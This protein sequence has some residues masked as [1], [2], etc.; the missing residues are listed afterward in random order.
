LYP[1][2][3]ELAREFAIDVQSNPELEA[4]V[5]TPGQE[6][7]EQAVRWLDEMDERIQVHQ[8][9]QFLQTS[10]VMNP[11]GV[12]VLLQHFLGKTPKSDA[13]RDKVDFLL[14]QYFSQLAPTGV[15]DAEVDLGYV[16][17]TLQ[18]VLGQVE[19][20]APV[21]LNALDRILE[22]ARR[23]KSLDELLHGGV[24][25]QGRKAKT[26]AGELFYLPVALTAFTRFG[27]L[28]RRAFFRLM[29]GDLNI[30][31]DGLTEL[32]EKGVQTIDCRR[33]QFS[34][35]EP[36]IRLRMICQ[37][38]KV[39]FQAEYSSGSPLRMLVD[40]RASVE[41]ALGRGK[42]PAVDAKSKGAPAAGA[43]GTAVKAEVAA[44]PLPAAP[45]AAASAK[46]AGS[47]KPSAPGKPV[48]AAARAAAA[49]GNVTASTP[50]AAAQPAA[51]ERA[52]APEAEGK[53]ES[54]AE[55]AEF[56]VSSG[57]EWDPDAAS[58]G[59]KA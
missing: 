5:E 35:Q 12:L 57:S 30:I 14:V 46:T 21:W 53:G 28:M 13:I 32:D 56:E 7:V 39:M 40:L 6:V 27:Y 18:P 3:F 42:T 49:A 11:E 45:R 25:E 48:P 33:A 20:K 47:L 37:S 58:S 16:A 41:H 52:Q 55:P 22:T 38:W 8:L 9:R 31:L 50:R 43:P 1:I 24:L 10:A 15:D 44:K 51:T 59:K 34:A 23:C 4:G 54:K 26:Q 17:Q 36:I 29:L 2:Y 19:L